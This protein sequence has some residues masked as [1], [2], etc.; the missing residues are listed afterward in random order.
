M[1]LHRKAFN[2][3]MTYKYINM[4]YMNNY[5]GVLIYLSGL[6]HFVAINFICPRIEVIHILASLTQMIFTDY[7]IT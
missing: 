4:L 6:C 5:E 2:Q 7:F 3:I 1:E